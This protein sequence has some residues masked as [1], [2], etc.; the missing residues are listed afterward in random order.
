MDKVLVVKAIEPNFNTMGGP[1]VM[2]VGGGGRS[3]DG[4][5]VGRTKR[6]VAGGVAGGLVGVAGA[7]A[8]QHRSLGSLVQ[9]MISGGAQGKAL[10]GAFGRSKLALVGRQRQARADY[11]EEANRDYAR[12]GAEGRFDN[13][14]YDGN[15][16]MNAA[17]RRN[18]VKEVNEEDA[19]EQSRRDNAYEQSRAGAAGRDFGARQAEDAAMTAGLRE[20]F[21]AD[22]KGRTEEDFTNRHNEYMNS[23][24]MKEGEVRVDPPQGPNMTA[25][26]PSPRQPVGDKNRQLGMTAV[27]PSPPIQ[28]KN[29]PSAPDLANLSAPSAPDLD[30]LNQQNL[31]N[32]MNGKVAVADSSGTSFTEEQVAEMSIDDMMAELGGPP[33]TPTQGAG[34]IVSLGADNKPPM[35]PIPP[36]ATPPAGSV[37]SGNESAD[38]DAGKLQQ[39]GFNNTTEGEPSDIQ[40]PNLGGSSN[41]KEDPAGPAGQSP[42]T[43]VGIQQQQEKA[44]QAEKV[45][46]VPSNTSLLRF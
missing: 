18:R 3:R 43:L 5:A 25:V 40:Y 34:S 27:T 30:A 10:G 2:M 13:R 31:L 12:M 8:G 20:R 37:G 36:L 4:P 21:M 14:K 24:S 35:M 45:G 28:A 22:G 26:A 23:E 19:K 15:V 44:R 7:L 17:V 46:V 41:D 1:P 39:D 6:E 9:G 33:P 11:D 38:T 29:A 42:Q 32:D 16:P